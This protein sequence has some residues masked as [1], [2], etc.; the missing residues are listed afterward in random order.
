MDKGKDENK[1]FDKVETDK[2]RMKRMHEE[3][4]ECMKKERKKGETDNG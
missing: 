1:N 2:E 3:C 4:R